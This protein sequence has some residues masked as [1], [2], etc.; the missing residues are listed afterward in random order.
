MDEPKKELPYNLTEKPPFAYDRAETVLLPL[1]FGMGYLFI[2]LIVGYGSGL[3]VALFFAC[4]YAVT[5]TYMALAGIRVQNRAESTV[6]GILTLLLTVPFLLYDGRGGRQLVLLFCLTCVTALQLMTMLGGRKRPF[7]DDGMALDM[8][9]A[10][11]VLPFGN[12]GTPWKTL[13]TIAKRGRLVIGILAGVIVSIPLLFIVIRLLIRADG[14]FESL[15][16][17]VSVSENVWTTLQQF[18]FGIPFATVAFGMLYGLRHKGHVTV[19]KPMG[20]ARTRK[21]PVG[22]AMGFLIPVCIVY[23]VYL[24]SQ[25]AYFLGGFAGFLPEGFTYAEYARRGFFELCAV[26]VINMGLILAVICFL[27]T[28]QRALRAVLCTFFGVVSLLLTATAMAKMLLYIRVYGLTPLRMQT[29]WFM[30]ALALTFV[31]TL[32][33]LYIPRFRLW[34]TLAVTAAAMLLVFAYVDADAVALSY[35]INAI[36]SGTLTAS[37]NP[38]V[39]AGFEQYELEQMSDGIVPYLRA[40]EDH[41]AASGA[42]RER[43]PREEQ[44]D[45]LYW[46]LSTRRARTYFT[47]G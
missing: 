33:R 26:C 19:E 44:E 15:M 40:H 20:L 11:T 22:A 10:V 5:F 12:L 45:L 2:R 23:A 25:F 6:L 43:D 14:V 38:A 24:V 39:F 35:N 41:P 27:K 29:S 46:N 8:L 13:G 1:C 3:A 47:Q 18:L 21:V 31:Y 37:T 42:L 16:Q 30:I 32:L 4:V 7:R 34:Q 28:G 17:R 36:E 9:G